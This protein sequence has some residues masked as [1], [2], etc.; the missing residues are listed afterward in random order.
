MSDGD[1]IALCVALVAAFGLLLSFAGRAERHSRLVAR[2]VHFL[3]SYRQVPRFRAARMLL[4]SLL[5]VVELFVGGAAF[6]PLAGPY[7]DASGPPPAHVVVF[8]VL[9]LVGFAALGLATIVVARTGRPAWLVMKP[10]RGLTSDQ[11]EDW[12]DTHADWEQALRARRRRR[13]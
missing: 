9:W 4:P 6:V 5:F 13:D 8:V 10:I 3:A 12:I 1:L 7:R 11:I 2:W